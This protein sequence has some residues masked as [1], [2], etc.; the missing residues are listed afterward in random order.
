VPR[1]QDSRELRLIRIENLIEQNDKTVE[2]LKSD[3]ADEQKKGDMKS[4]RIDQLE[5]ELS[6]HKKLKETASQKTTTPKDQ[7]KWKNK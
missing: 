6:A 7:G 5:K 1:N 4:Q 2:K 3:F